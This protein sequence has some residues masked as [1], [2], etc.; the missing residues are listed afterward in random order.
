MRDHTWFEMRDIRK[1][2][3]SK[4]VWIPLRV[5]EESHTGERGSIGFEEEVFALGS[6]A[7]HTKH[8]QRAEAL[9]WSDIGIGHAQRSLVLESGYKP[10]DVFQA[11]DGTCLG[12]DLV[13]GQEFDGSEEHVWHL[14][15]DL[16]IALGLLREGDVWL[17][18]QEGYEE[19]AHLKRSASGAPVRLE[20]RASHLGDY[21]AAR[22]LA[23]RVA[24]YRIRSTVEEETSHIP[25]SSED[26]RELVGGDRFEARVR[27]IHEGG[28]VFGAQTAVFHMGRTDVDAEEDVPVFGAPEE[29]NIQTR[30]WSMKSQRRM[31]FDVS[32]ELW[33][34]EWFEPA[35]TSPRVRGDKAPSSCFFI[36]E[37]SGKRES[38]DNLRDEAVHRWLWFRPGVIGELAQRRGGALHWYTRD[39]GEVAPVYGYGIHFGVNQ[40][41]LINVY[42]LDIARLPEW[43][44]VIWMG[45][46][47]APD[48]KVSEELLLSQMRADP[49]ETIAPEE[50]FALALARLDAACNSRWKAPLLRQHPQGPTILRT[51]HRFRALNPEGLLALAKDIARLTVDS[52][53]VGPLQ[54]LVPLTK[55]EKRGSIKSLEHALATI[56]QPEEARR[57]MS[58]LVGVYELR[59]SDAHLPAANMDNAFLLVGIDLSA[60]TIRQSMQMM[61]AAAIAFEEI[62]D[63]IEKRML[64]PT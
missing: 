12:I 17:C 8:R 37:P 60:S 26:L 30:S 46:N 61:E 9:G 38:A 2:W 36:T 45:F 42:A 13:L 16:I 1:R 51:I 10:A 4:A 47:A 5:Y 32:G 3:F 24:T 52:I 34:T 49:A 33:R 55:G 62:S 43:Q 29:S 20:I 35:T 54:T 39:T 57:M 7:F 58:P 28:S 59:L 44:K 25:W 22:D 19:V 15:Q 40:K 41:E 31:L 50:R 48:G 53:D 63:T 21:L 18:P 11:R 56:V 64:A 27:A 6:V 23:L 14:H